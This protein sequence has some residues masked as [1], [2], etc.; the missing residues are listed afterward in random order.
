VVLVVWIRKTTIKWC[1]KKYGGGYE[2]EILL[3][4]F[5]KKCNGQC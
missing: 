2:S 5:E 4:I 1:H 3:V